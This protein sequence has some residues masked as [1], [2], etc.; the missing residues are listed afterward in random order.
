M[1]DEFHDWKRGGLLT[2]RCD[3]LS[4]AI[5]SEKEV[6]FESGAPLVFL[7]FTFSSA[8]DVPKDVFDEL[9]DGKPTIVYKVLS[10][11]GIAWREA[12]FCEHE[13]IG[14]S[15]DDSTLLIER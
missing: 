7:G 4:F 9:T 13:F 12:S 11:S 3:R 15:E 5:N 8:H 10:P 1:S 2:V 6:T 14:P